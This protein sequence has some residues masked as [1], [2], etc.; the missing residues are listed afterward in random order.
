MIQEQMKKIKSIFGFDNTDDNNKNNKKKIENLVFFVIILI[1]TIIFINMILK[2]NKNNK[3][4]E[5][6]I[7]TKTL[8]DT[9]KENTTEQIDDSLQ[10]KLE[11]ILSNI[12]GVG[13]TKVLLTY[14][15]S[16]QSIPLYNEDSSTSNTEEKDTSGGTR[17]INQN[18]SKKE[19]IYQE[20]NGEK[21]PVTQSTI[22]PKIEGAVV[23]AKGANNSEIRLK[24]T[25]A[26]EAA[27]G[28]PTHKIQVFPLASQ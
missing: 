25:Q 13:D 15:Q 16:S 1:I 20:I 3:T 9:K 11:T 7:Y 17:V 28:I 14:S 18:N 24:I 21:V 26:V 4:H 5:N 10:G 23:L 6:T 19:V 12:E 8:A 2:D 22:N 27:T